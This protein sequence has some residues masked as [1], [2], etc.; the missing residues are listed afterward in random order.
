MIM[1]LGLYGFLS[2]QDPVLNDQL[3]CDGWILK[4]GWFDKP[5]IELERLDTNKHKSFGTKFSFELANVVGAYNVF[6][7]RFSINIYNPDRLGMCGNG[8]LYVDK[9][10]WTLKDKQ[11]T[12]DLKGGYRLEGEFHYIIRYDVKMIDK[13]KMVLTQNKIIKNHKKTHNY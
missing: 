13:D 12:L 6:E 5:V 1:F 2:A 10:E 7:R 4:K 3:L 8:M 9:G 11:L